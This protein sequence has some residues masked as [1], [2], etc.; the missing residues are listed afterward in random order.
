LFRD[1]L[2]HK[3]EADKLLKIKGVELGGGKTKLRR[4]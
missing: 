3:N 4:Y 1:K 2:A